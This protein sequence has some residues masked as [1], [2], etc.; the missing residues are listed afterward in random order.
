MNYALI[1]KE[2]RKAVPPCLTLKLASLNNPCR[3]IGFN[4][5]LFKETSGEIEVVILI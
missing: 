1:P 5:Q 2:K 4:W 3:N